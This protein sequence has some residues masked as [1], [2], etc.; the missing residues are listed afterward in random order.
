VR[1][2]CG[3]PASRTNARVLLLSLHASPVY[4]APPSVPRIHPPTHTRT[5]TPIGLS[6]QLLLTCDTHAHP[7]LPGAPSNA[8]AHIS[9]PAFGSCAQSP[10]PTTTSN[11]TTTNSLTCLV[12]CDRAHVTVC[13]FQSFP[14]INPRTCCWGGRE[15]EGRG[16]GGDARGGRGQ[17][18]RRPRRRRRPQT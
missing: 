17:G 2:P 7:F 11:G 12:S 18:Q 13:L 1:H 5:Q 4:T 8:R 14:E 6:L 15:G 9:P 10:P 3:T 16:G